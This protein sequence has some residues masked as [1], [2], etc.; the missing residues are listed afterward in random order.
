MTE[1]IAETLQELTL[2]IMKTVQE[3]V[4]KGEFQPEKELA[5]RWK[6][7]NFRY[8]DAG[9]TQSQARGDYFTKESWFRASLKV[10]ER[11]KQT[12]SYSNSHEQLRKTFGDDVKFTSGLE[13]FAD[14]VIHSCFYEP[15]T[16][17]ARINSLIA[18]FLK[19]L[20]REP[21]KYGAEVELD[22]IVLRPET[23]ELDFGITLR[24]PKIEDLEK[25]MP[26]YVPM[27]PN[28]LLPN[29]SAY[30][31]IEFLGRA[32][33]EVQI[34]VE[35]AITTLRLFR[36]GSVK[37]SSYR[38]YSDS[39]TDMMARGTLR[40]HNEEPAL[41][42]YVVTVE[43]ATKLRKFWHAIADYLPPALFEF[44]QTKADHLTIAYT[45]YSDGLLQNGVIERRIAN[46]MM[47]MES[48][49]L[50]RGETQELAYRLGVRV[51]KLLCMLGFD[52]HE[53]KRNLSDAYRIR[54]LF[55]HGSQLSYKE[56]RKLELKYKTLK[57]L[58]VTVLDYLRISIIV[59]ILLKK[60]KDELIDILD[61]SLIDNQK[62]D[63]LRSLL[64]STKGVI[65]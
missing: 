62:E 26:A 48:L 22:G 18:N 15:L 1:N 8:T 24:Q 53:V 55:A 44:D 39:V 4:S 52:H 30:L 16:K 3:G 10:L 61:D 37:Y 63:Q 56:K 11:I 57:N 35:R 29:P 33:R 36:V 58:L 27:A 31:T 6:L 65:G 47:G 45:R 34:K 2:T 23:I 64:S 41:D 32:A 54:S 7:Q 60:G 50:K 59:A 49:Y 14:Q 43:E 38:M 20:R 9:I 12:N 46:A 40:S 5:F 13:T 25:E 21:V 17:D 28:F 42:K 19:D 51:G